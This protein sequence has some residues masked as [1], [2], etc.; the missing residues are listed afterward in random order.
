[1]TET[2]SGGRKR[3]RSWLFLLI[4]LLLICLC[5]LTPTMAR[6]SWGGML[7]PIGDFVEQITCRVPQLATVAIVCPSGGRTPEEQACGTP[8]IGGDP[9]A[10]PYN[11]SCKDFSQDTA[12]VMYSACWNDEVCQDVPPPSGG[13]CK[14]ACNPEKPNCAEGL[15]CRQASDNLYV[16]WGETCAQEPDPS[17]GRCYAACQP[18]AR[19][20]D[21]GLDCKQQANGGWVCFGEA[22][23]PPPS[24]GDCNQACDPEQKEGCRQGLACVKNDAGAYV[25]WD[26][27]TC[28][29]PPTTTGCF[30]PCAPA[31]FTAAYTNAASCDPGLTCTP[32]EQGGP[33]CWNENCGT[34]PPT[35]GGCYESCATF[36][37][38]SAVIS[39]CTQGLSCVQN[40]N[41]GAYFCYGDT[42]SPPP[43]GGCNAPCA[44]DTTCNRGLT[45]QPVGTAPA[46]TAANVGKVCW[47]DD[48]CNVPPPTGGGCDTACT[49]NVTTAFNQCMPGLSCLPEPDGGYVC[50]SP[51]VCGETPPPSTGYCGDPC[52]PLKPNCV[53][54]TS[55]I[56]SPNGGYVCWGPNVCLGGGTSPGGCGALCGNNA[57]SNGLTCTLQSDGRY[58]CWN[59]NICSTAPSVT[60]V[61][62]GIPCTCGDGICEQ[63]RCNELQQNCPADCG[64][65]DPCAGSVCGDGVCRCGEDA[66][67]CKQDCGQSTTVP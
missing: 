52:D 27:Q 25:C 11:L 47:S 8:C 34:P 32:Q 26:G 33:I 6:Q 29:P 20:C 36:T 37:T 53:V 18:N 3:D 23:D 58:L 24:T 63:E 67:N 66:R 17:G 1:M 12:G 31:T 16:C 51:Q 14:A 4:L 49:P 28:N 39:T 65:G 22:C 7:K 9:N 64:S 42:C 60:E 13:S 40:P 10:C 45:C 61:P 54:G 62:T 35:T 2:A 5:C 19:T 15:S 50:W 57:C 21:N 30:A 46:T 48:V 44:D 55:C 56:T 59:A 43:G 41:S 38:G